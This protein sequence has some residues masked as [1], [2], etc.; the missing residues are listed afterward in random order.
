MMKG[1]IGIHESET[2]EHNL[3]IGTSLSAPSLLCSLKKGS[4]SGIEVLS[5]KETCLFGGK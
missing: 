1:E 2:N 3:G 5:R 4:G